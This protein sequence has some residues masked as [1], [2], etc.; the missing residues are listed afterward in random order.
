MASKTEIEIII[1]PDGSVKLDVKGIK[2]PTCLLEINKVA[3]AVGELKS[4][5]I[6][7]EYYEKTQTDIK[8]Q[9]GT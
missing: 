6:K 9:Q 7:P 1:S 8:K 4:T 5:D 2:G 3:N